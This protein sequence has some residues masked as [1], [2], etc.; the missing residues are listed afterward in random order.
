MIDLSR[1]GIIEVNRG[2]SFELPLFINQGTDITPIRYNMK[3]SNS[4]VYVGVMEPNQPFERAIIRKK[5]TKNDVNENGDIVVKF[6]SN[7]TVCLLPGK[8]YYQVKI[9]LYNNYDNNKE[10]CN[11]NTIV[12]MTQ[13][14]IVE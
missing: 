7:D 10:D 8:Y 2:D 9:K 1:N 14:I 11:I 13:F 5:Y 3:T 4:E 12:P 6:S